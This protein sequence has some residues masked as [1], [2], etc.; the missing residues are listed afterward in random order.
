MRLSIAWIVVAALAASACGDGG[1]GSPTAPSG[2]GGS[3]T[4]QT[5]IISVSG[6]LAFGDVNVGSSRDATITISNSGNATLTVTGLSVSGSL[7]SILT[8]SWT[9][10]TIAAGGSQSVTIRIQPTS[11]GALSGTLTVNGDQT[12]GNNSI[13][14]TANVISTFTGNWTGGH[15]ITQCNG[16]GSAQDLIC[17]AARGAF[18]VGS[19]MRFAFDLTQSGNAV[20]GT[21]DLGGT[22]GPVTG[23]VSNGVLTLSGTLRDTQGFTA[24]ITA[25]S[26]T[27]SGNTMSGTVSYTLTFSGLPGNA[28]I[29][30]TLNNVT[31]D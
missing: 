13:A 30:A 29:V 17:S 22:V 7:G 27:F 6:N 31:R 8:A 10:G 2:T 16:T 26:T 18:K 23:T 21:G 14:V 5:R 15:V 11:A 4:T 19:N 1:S 12:S 9:S 25:F 20:S 28:G 3:G 24:V